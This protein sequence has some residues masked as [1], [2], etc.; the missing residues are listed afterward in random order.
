MIYI[1]L[2]SC[3]LQSIAKDCSLFPSDYTKIVGKENEI[4]VQDIQEYFI[5]VK[6]NDTVTLTDQ[7]NKLTLLPPIYLK[8][9]NELVPNVNKVL[10]YSVLTTKSQ[11]MNKFQLLAIRNQ[12]E[13]ILAWTEKIVAGTQQRYPTF[14]KT[15]SLGRTDEVICQS[16]TILDINHLLIDC[17]QVNDQEPQ[18]YF[19]MISEKDAQQQLKIENAYPYQKNQQRYIVSTQNYIYRITL[20]TNNNPAII[21]LFTYDLVNKDIKLQKTINQELIQQYVNITEYSFD[22]VDAKI[23]P[24]DQIAILDKTGNVFL[25]QYYSSNDT[26]KFN[27]EGYLLGE[28][29]AFDY[30]FNHQEFVIVQKNSV[31]KSHRSYDS[32]EDLSNSKIHY[33]NDFIFLTS[34]TQIIAFDKYL[35]VSEI[36]QGDFSNVIADQTQNDFL[37]FTNTNI[38]HYLR[39]PHYRIQYHNNEQGITGNSILKLN[40]CQVTIEYQTVS[41]KSVDLVL[42]SKGNIQDSPFF[43]QKIFF[44]DF[45]VR[46]R[47]LVSGPKQ[48]ISFQKNTKNDQ[49]SGGNLTYIAVQGDTFDKYTNKNLSLTDLIFLQTVS[50][51]QSFDQPF[52]IITQNKQKE[53]AIYNCQS[54][55]AE[56]CQLSYQSKLDFEITKENTVIQYYFYQF[57]FITLLNEKT[58]FFYK[59]YSNSYLNRTITLKDEDEIK[60]IDSIYLSYSYLLLFSKAA[61]TIGVYNFEYVDL[62][63]IINP[64]KLSKLGFADWD[65]QRLYS[66]DFD[67]QLFVVNGEAQNQ[68]L[69]LNLTKTDFSFGYQM[70][71][72]QSQDIRIISFYERF[73]ILQQQ[74]QGK[75]TFQIYNRQDPTN[76]YLEKTPSF[77]D[78]QIESFDS[79][80]WVSY[81]GLLHVKAKSE[82]K[83]VILSYIVDLT[84]HNS[85]YC[86]QDWDP[87]N[88]FVAATQNTVFQFNKDNV[89]VYYIQRY[90]YVSYSVSFDDSTFISNQDYNIVYSNEQ[91][92]LVN[93]NFRLVNIYI[94]LK[95]SQDKLNITTNLTS[96]QEHNYIQDMGTDWFSGEVTQFELYLPQFN[97]QKAEIINPIEVVKPYY[98]NNTMNVVDFSTN[99]IFVLKNDSYVLISKKTNEVVVTEK[100]T[101]GYLC[102][103]V[104]ASFD[105]QVLIQCIKEELQY[106][107]GIQCENTNCKIGSSWLQI[108][109]EI[110][111]GYIDNENIFIIE[112]QEILAY[113]KNILDLSKAQNYGKVSV[114]DLDNFQYGL[115]IKKIKKNHYHVYCT[116]HNYAFIVLEYSIKENQ[117]QRTNKITFNLYDFINQNFYQLTGTIY[118]CIRTINVVITDTSYK[119]D[120]ILFATAGPHY[121]VHIEFSCTADQCSLEQKKIAFVLQ[122]Y[123]SFELLGY[124]FSN[125]RIVN[126]FVQVSY[127]DSGRIKL[128]QTIYQLPKVQTT[129]SAVIFFAA[130][131]PTYYYNRNFIQEEFYSYENQLY[132]ITNSEHIDQLGLYKIN[133]SP[134]LLL[135]GKFD[136]SSGY[137][138]VKND[139]SFDQIPITIQGPGGSDDDDHD[140]TTSSGHTGVWVALG[141][142]GGCLILGTGYYCYKRKK[143]KVDTL[144]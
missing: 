121:G 126:N 119:A 15:I 44:N 58:L 113:S 50:M 72:S 89:W 46:P 66:N 101:K 30:Q 78:Y 139:F 38:K 55:T 79:F 8:T 35:E 17:Y 97:D 22:M 77:Y 48:N 123:G 122:G 103:D 5:Q 60:S 33:S 40:D 62:L 137:I 132:Y 117:I 94:D 104:I 144:I 111:S 84:D 69:I 6:Y 116:D 138:R 39:N 1:T 141:I 106:V 25:L 27:Q 18:T 124:I 102:Q 43:T 53:L 49:N 41:A 100:I 95:I 65:P 7:N 29:F 64:E 63:Y 74:A 67:Q 4:I 93:K 130:L 42:V 81:N 13:Q 52:S 92:L 59:Y 91:L 2:L 131:R 120:F 11:W 107:G 105:S 34:P 61:K 24:T 83:S 118:S 20:K 23:S 19:Y 143:T 31:Q 96:N 76:I 90:P 99:Y 26:I 75:F 28:S 3:I 136:K 115:T 51:A 85:L 112:R 98:Q 21:E 134:Q 135:N 9:N 16:S 57:T 88:Q 12:D 70:A 10:S 140:N 80:F 54:R 86:V 108:S 73:A 47:Q 129:N 37:V 128:V 142:F 45:N 114:N 68:L 109:E 82:F 36:A 127:T 87:V 125:V 110:I 56:I 133:S 71:I 14:D 32:L